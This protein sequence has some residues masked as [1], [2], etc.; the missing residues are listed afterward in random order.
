MNLL[1]CVNYSQEFT[2]FWY[3]FPLHA[4]TK[5]T[6]KSSTKAQN[7]CTFLRQFDPYTLTVAIHW[8]ILDLFFFYL[9]TNKQNYKTR[10]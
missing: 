2:V 6:L 7:E 10:K 3:F 8:N 9:K 5:S 1:D 4:H